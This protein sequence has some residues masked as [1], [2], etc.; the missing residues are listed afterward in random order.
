MRDLAPNVVDAYLWLSTPGFESGACL[1]QRG[2]Y[3]FHLSEALSLV[4]HANPRL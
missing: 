1:G 3:G 2:G 4:R